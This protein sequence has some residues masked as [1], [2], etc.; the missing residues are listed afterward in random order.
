MWRCSWNKSSKKILY[1]ITRRRYVTSTLVSYALLHNYIPFERRVKNNMNVQVWC[2]FSQL[3]CTKRRHTIVLK[4][5]HFYQFEWKNLTTNFHIKIT[6]VVSSLSTYS[7]IKKSME[8]QIGNRRIYVFLFI[9]KC[10]KRT[11]NSHF[12][13]L[14]ISLFVAIGAGVVRM[15]IFIEDLERKVSIHKHS[16]EK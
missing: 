16:R 4:I 5:Q 10:F 11:W 14:L 1:Y 6:L 2:F 15:M 8:C 12:D 3:S 9:F 7:S 13:V